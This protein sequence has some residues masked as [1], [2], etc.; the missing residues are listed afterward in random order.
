MQR[1]SIDLETYSPVDIKSGG[2]YKYAEEAEILLFAYSLNGADPICLDL[3][4]QALPDWIFKA[5]T[6]PNYLKVAYNASFE[7]AILNAVYG[8]YTPPEQWECTMVRAAMA[9]LPLSLDDSSTALGLQEKKDWT[10]KAL[11][12]YFCI[13]CKPTKVNGERTRNYPEHAPDKW[14]QFMSYCRQDVVT[15]MAVSKKLSWF[16][17]P[18]NEKKLWC[19]DQRRN[20]RGVAIDIKLI[21]NAIEL[22]AIFREALLKEA[23]ELTGLKN[24]NSVAQ[25]KKWLSEEMDEEIKSLSKATVTKLMA[26]AD[27]GKAKRVLQ[28]R[29][30]LAK[31]SIKKYQAMLNAACKD[32]R[33]RGLIQFY[34][35]GRT[36]RDAGRIAQPQNYPR[37]T[38]SDEMLAMARE[39]VLQKDVEMID[40]CFDNLA[41][42][43]SQLTRTAF[44]PAKGNK[45]I[46][47]DFSAIEAIVIAFFA[48]E[49]WVLN[50]FKTHGKFYEATA[51]QMFK[52]P[53]ESIGKNSDLRQRGKV[54]ALALG[55]Q[56]SVGALT[57]MGALDLGIKEEEL[58]PIVDAWRAANPNIVQFWWDLER[59]AK[60][61]IK[62]GTY[63]GVGTKGIAFSM[64][65]GNLLMH[66]PSGR[67][68]CYQGAHLK[69]VW[70]SKGK[71]LGYTAKRC[72][73]G[74]FVL[75]NDILL[76]ASQF[77]IEEEKQNAEDFGTVIK[78][79]FYGVI[80]L[81]ELEL[82][83]SVQ[84]RELLLFWGTNQTTKKWELQSTY[85]GKLAE[86]FTQA[87]ARDCLKNGEINL[88]EAGYDV[89]LPVHDET[90][91]DVA[92][93]SLEEVNKLMVKPAPWML[94]MPLKA[95]GFEGYYYQ[96]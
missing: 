11:I 44:I 22:D 31:S 91:S 24:A 85:A 88:A 15:E 76:W 92:E 60:N 5:L 62:T 71:I 65:A 14:A 30:L 54:A 1:L 83:Q 90:V 46:V 55:Y 57:T 80:T 17:I 23:V 33:I 8:I 70:V 18:A 39:L 56:G 40:I 36:G 66:L 59:A 9:G 42:I 52:V 49:Q 34:G 16:E 81:V 45:F 50:V 43:L 61:A 27:E 74:R 25:L 58:K 7:R 41:D 79:D 96:K 93:G 2:A 19:L 63:Q 51:A 21:Q 68:L 72:V 47:S 3:T 13:P 26:K 82:L 12:R 29:S 20:E 67:F 73:L 69:E 6:D 78:H 37:I 75:N 38:L 53:V 35:A 89:V 95:A 64:K 4:K 77:D 32:G 48:G 10:G 94:N 86:N 84:R 28:I 87:A